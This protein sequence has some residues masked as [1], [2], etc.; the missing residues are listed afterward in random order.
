MVNY[1]NGFTWTDVYTMT[2][3]WRR[4]Y[5]KKLVDAKKKEADEYKKANKKGACENKHL[6]YNPNRIL[7]FFRVTLTELIDT[8]GSVD[9]VLFTGVEWVRG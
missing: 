9:K 8:T 4:F 2:I 7:L 6:I 3:H 1:G 5:F